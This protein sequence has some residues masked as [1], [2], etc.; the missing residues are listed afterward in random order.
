M[1][2]RKRSKS[3]KKGWR[4]RRWNAVKDAISVRTFDVWE[5]LPRSEIESIL[6]F[7]AITLRETRSGRD[8]HVRETIANKIEGNGKRIQFF[9]DVMQKEFGLLE[10]EVKSILFSPIP[11]IGRT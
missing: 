5:K 8:K 11:K 7:R 2:S 3:G 9:F 10:H 4:T 1:V 6:D